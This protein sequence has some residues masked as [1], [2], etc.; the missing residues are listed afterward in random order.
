MDSWREEK[1]AVDSNFFHLWHILHVDIN[2]HM[3]STSLHNVC[4]F[5]EWRLKEDKHGE[6]HQTRE[7]KKIMNI[8]Y[9]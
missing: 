4:N 7:F 3:L 8:N 6:K 5:K 2:F 9:T 1:Q